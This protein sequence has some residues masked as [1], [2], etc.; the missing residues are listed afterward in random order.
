[1]SVSFIKKEDVLII[2]SVLFFMNSGNYIIFKIK[3]PKTA[4]TMGPATGIHE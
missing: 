2:Q 1:M 4:P 3:A